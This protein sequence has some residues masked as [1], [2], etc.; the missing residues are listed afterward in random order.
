MRAIVLAALLLVQAGTARADET[1][2]NC[3]LP[4]IKGKPMAW[5]LKLN[6]AAGTVQV[7]RGAGYIEKVAVFRPRSVT[8]KLFSAMVEISRVDG[9]IKQT[10]TRKDGSRAGRGQCAVA[11]KRSF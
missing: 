5:A 10:P 2:L 7:S 6:E 3:T 8:F 4:D 11:V 9:S 1:L